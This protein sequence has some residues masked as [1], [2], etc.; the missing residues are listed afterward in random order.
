M[1]NEVV[2]KSLNLIG[3]LL[4]GLNASAWDGGTDEADWRALTDRVASN[5]TELA[6]LTAQ[7]D[8]AGLN[9]DYAAVSKTVIDRFLV[10]SQYD[11][12]HPEI[13][14]N[15]VAAVWWRGK[16]PNSATYHIELPF[17]EMQ[18][19]LD[20]SNNAMD[21]LRQQLASNISLEDPSDF[22]TGTLVLTNRF[23][24]LDG[25]PVFPSTFTWMLKDEEDL[26]QAFGR[27]GGRSYSL[28]SVDSDNTVNAGNRNAMAADLYAQSAD[29]IGPQQIFLGHQADS[30]MIS[31]HPE[32]LDGARNFTKYDIDSPLIRGWLTTLFEGI[33]PTACGPAGSGN[34]PRIHLLA[35]E[36]SFSTREG[37][38]LASNG[39][40]DHTM[41][42]YKEW[43]TAKYTTVSNLNMT[44][45]TSYADF[46]AAKAGMIIPVPLSLQGGPIWYDWCR[47]NMDRVNEWFS[48][49]KNGTQSNDPAGSPVTIKLLGGTLSDEYRDAGID[50]EYL[51]KLQDVMGADNHVVPLG[52]S[53]LNIKFSMEWTNRYALAWMEQSMMMDFTKSLC[54]DK[55]FYDSEWHGLSTDRWCHFS[56]GRDY[57][58]TALWLGFTHGMSAMQA[59]YFP[60]K[61]DGSLRGD[62][63]AVIGSAATLP[64]AV[65]SYG[66][67][68]KELNAHAGS[69]TALVPET[70]SFMLYYCEEAAIQDTEYTADLTDVYD[71]LKLL[72]ISVGF[73]TPTEISNVSTLNQT[74]IIPPTAYMS[75]VSLAALQTYEGAGG[76]LVQ[77][78]GATASFGKNEQGGSRSSSGLT[79]FASVAFSEV[80][81][82]ADSLTIAL[83][84][85]KPSLPVQTLILSPDLQPAYGVLSSQ[86]IDPATGNTTVVLINVSKDT[87][88]VVLKESGLP[89]GLRNLITQQLLTSSPV[90]EPCDVL[91]LQ[92][93]HSIPPPSVPLQAPSPVTTVVQFTGSE[94]YATGDLTAHSDWTGP[95]GNMVNP[96]GAGYNGAQGIV[97]VSLNAWVKGVYSA[98]LSSASAGDEI[99][100][101]SVFKFTSTNSVIGAKDLIN[102]MFY[103]ESTGGDFM[104][105]GVRRTSSGGFDFIVV[106]QNGNRFSTGVSSSLA[107]L[108]S[109]LGTSDWLEFSV[110]L[111]RGA[112][113]DDWAMDLTLMNL[114]SNSIIETFSAGGLGSTP[115]FFAAETLYGGFSSSMIAMISSRVIDCFSYTV[116][117]QTGWQQFVS[118]YGLGGSV[119]NDFDHDG[120]FDYVEYALGG[121]PVNSAS[122]GTMPSIVYA[123]DSYVSLYNLEITNAHPGITYL[124]EWTDSLV[125]NGWNQTWDSTVIVPSAIP[126]YDEVE[127]KIYGGTNDHLFFRLQ[128]IVP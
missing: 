122:Q 102:L 52:A 79:P 4:V 73:T 62:M 118:N 108:V 74:V 23:Y 107:G 89:V 99:T 20:L 88:T 68:F 104:R 67:T 22:S 26:L 93:D 55:P 94:G 75:D 83:N 61:H 57:V 91:L 101:S 9:T 84:A 112:S 58:R 113:S 95:L 27:V 87:R 92:T 53:D 8:M 59:W 38:W 120:Q 17:D 109:D 76:N 70:R 116:P 82:M 3:F 66:R 6:S 15:A 34:Q 48:F 78:N 45:G 60:R 46:D 119:T 81:A 103:D 123:H 86:W 128:I 24:T 40:S 54:P 69:I 114:V 90:M 80:Y 5:K 39:V 32:V 19:C 7:A 71:A 49:L 117:G 96:N 28:T 64:K 97:D 33:L 29:N 127:R 43:I 16:I 51:T 115:D 44:Y 1:F 125:S 42:K 21:E 106:N 25:N 50:L 105:A 111:T 11:R 31:S 110:T 37:G 85:L 36:P 18:E 12:D 13:M 100:L 35:N 65:D 77:V 30:W 124:A 2:K 63:G 72:N 10:Y 47:F 98:G 126:G 41:A 56:M 121:N 14:S